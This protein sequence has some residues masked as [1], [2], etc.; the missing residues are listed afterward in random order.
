M[1]IFKNS[2]PAS[3]AL[4][5]LLVISVFTLI[6]VLGMSQVSVTKSYQYFNNASNRNV[7]YVAEGCLDEALIR[8]EDDPLFSQTTLTLDAE[9]SCTVTVSGSTTKTISIIVNFLMYTQTYQAQAS[10]NEVGEAN[11]LTLLQWQEI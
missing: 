3:V 1:K 5:S 8:L 9:T 7:Y 4:I 6:L 10:L 11:N 2:Y